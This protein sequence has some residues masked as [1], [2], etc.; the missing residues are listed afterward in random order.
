LKRSHNEDFV[1]VDEHARIVVLADGMGGCKAG[2]VASHMTAN[3][4]MDGLREGSVVD[5]R[6]AYERPEDASDDDGPRLNVSAM[7]AD[8]SDLTDEPEGTPVSL[9]TTPD[10]A[11]P[12]EGLGPLFGAEVTG[13]FEEIEIT[14]FGAAGPVHDDE[15]TRLVGGLETSRLSCR[16]RETTVNEKVRTDLTSSRAAS[17]QSGCEVSPS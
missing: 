13:E 10:D 3:I 8:C 15:Y 14:E 11:T 9:L 12:D 7:Y 5:V 2:E 17:C 6:E 16:L 1:L 4:V